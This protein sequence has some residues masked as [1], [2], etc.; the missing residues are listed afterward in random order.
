MP[1]ED[2]LVT[3]PN[4]K[5]SSREEARAAPSDQ[6]EV[7]IVIPCLNEERVSGRTGIYDILAKHQ[8]TAEWR[9]RELAAERPH[10]VLAHDV[11]LER[12]SGF[13]V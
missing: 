6:V 13:R 1:N 2:S 10:Q 11:A 7:S 8:I 9:H 5:M 4:Y 12:G 3:N